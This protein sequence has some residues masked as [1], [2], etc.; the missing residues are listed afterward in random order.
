MLDLVVMVDIVLLYVLYLH[1]CQT[2]IGCQ[3]LDIAL[4]KCI[5]VNPLITTQQIIYALVVNTL[6]ELSVQTGGNLQVAELRVGVVEVDDRLLQVVVTAL[7]NVGCRCSRVCKV[8]GLVGSVY[9]VPV[10]L[11]C[12]VVTRFPQVS[13]LL[14]GSHIHRVADN[15]AVIGQLCYCAIRANKA[16]RIL[17]RSVVL[18][19]EF[20]IA[21]ELSVIEE[22]RQVTIVVR[23]RVGSVVECQCRVGIE[24]VVV[25]G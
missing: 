4:G 1:L 12:F 14:I 6:C 16:E 25:T 5:H 13:Q 19:Y 21:C 23:T 24:C 18:G 15:I 20:A 8:V 17:C 9:S 7:L 2:D 22:R 11:R 10:N 3:I